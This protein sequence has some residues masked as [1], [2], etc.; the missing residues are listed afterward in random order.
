MRTR[1]YDTDTYKPVITAPESGWT[2]EDRDQLQRE[3]STREYL[4]FARTKK[5]EVLRISRPPFN[6][7]SIRLNTT[8]TTK[9]RVRYEELESLGTCPPAEDSALGELKQSIRDLKDSQ[10]GRVTIDVLPAP[11]ADDPTRPAMLIKRAAEEVEAERT[12]AHAERAHA[13]LSASSAHRWL[14]CTPAPHLEAQHPDSESEAAAEGTIAHE[15]AEHKLRQALDEPTQR[16]DSEWIDE[17]ME[18]HTD[19]YVDHVMAELHRTQE[20]SPGA[21]LAI[22]QRL[23]FSHI[24]PNGF[25]TADATIVGDG[26]MTVVD[27]KYGKG[28]KV[29]AEDNPQMRLYALGALAQFGMIYDIHTVRMVIFQPR[30]NNISTDEISVDALTQWAEDVVRPAAALAI[31]GEGQLQAGTWCQFC[32]HAP[33]CTA[34]AQQMFAPIPTTG[35]ALTPAAPDPDTLTDEQITQIV[36]VSTELKK[37]LG[38]VEA[39]ALAQANNGHVYPGLKLVEGRSVR[40]YTD[41]EAVAAVV[42]S[43]TAEDPYKPREV[44]GITAMTK[45]LGKKQFDELLGQYVHKPEGKPALVPVSDKRPA[46]EVATA[47]TVFQP[48]G[49]S[50]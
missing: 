13:L 17:D 32:R 18:D 10:P 44:L 35:D 45:L 24:V 15:L 19:N 11:G 38:K 12:P 48:I 46:L 42:T 14:H 22:E 9:T 36:S 16:P 20:E 50:A 26:T 31:A 29:D 4:I 1:D 7:K 27:F 49:E 30:I 39:H 37:W 40:K 5:G 25:G 8:H 23:D 3:A 2:F 41:T 21:F 6:A 33:Q 34:L 43:E 28:V 47:E